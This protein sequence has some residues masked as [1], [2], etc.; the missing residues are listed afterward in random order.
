MVHEVLICSAFELNLVVSIVEVGLS[1][2]VRVQ[3]LRCAVTL[4]EVKS[5]LIGSR[6]DRNLR[7]HL[8][9][10]LLEII[11]HFQMAALNFILTAR[12]SHGQ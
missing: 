8:K 7:A 1:K 2:L 10:C 5:I 3:G 4:F 9:V 12:T 11:S 6:V